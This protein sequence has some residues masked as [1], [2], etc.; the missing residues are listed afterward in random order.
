[1]L[2]NIIFLFHKN[3]IYIYFF[4]VI[5]YFTFARIQS[6]FLSVALSAL[7]TYDLYR[8]GKGDEAAAFEDA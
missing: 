2:H 8:Q 1:M 5:C 4:I 7:D 6:M 3:I